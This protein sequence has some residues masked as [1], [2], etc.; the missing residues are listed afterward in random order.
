MKPSGFLAR[1][2]YAFLIFAML[3]M[4]YTPYCLTA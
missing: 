2:L 4:H 3:H 1:I